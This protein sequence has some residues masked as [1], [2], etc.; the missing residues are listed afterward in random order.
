MRTH[1]WVT[2]Q[3]TRE[4]AMS[5][6][7]IS[8]LV[9][10]SC[11]SRTVAIARTWCATCSPAPNTARDRASRRLRASTATAVAAAVRSAVTRPDSM[12]ASGWP[13]APSNSCT[14]PTMLGSPSRAGRP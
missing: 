13:V 14:R 5:R 7:S 8:F 2:S 12:I 10:A 4:A 11:S 9:G 6:G 1:W 3:T